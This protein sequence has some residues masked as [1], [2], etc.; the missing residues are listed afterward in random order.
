MCLSFACSFICFLVEWWTWRG[1][2]SGKPPSL[3]EVTE[4]S[5]APQNAM[6]AVGSREPIF[7]ATVNGRRWIFLGRQAGRLVRRPGKCAEYSTASKAAR[8]TKFIRHNWHQKQT[9]PPASKSKTTAAACLMP[10]ARDSPPP[11]HLCK[12]AGI[13]S[14][15]FAG[16]T[17]HQKR[18]P[19][20]D[21]RFLNLD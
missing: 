4:K 12:I 5:E 20:R 3:G 18:E 14:V 2:A 21:C 7:A 10:C 11:Q 17:A 1:G 13:Q 19:K 15:S 16:E 9:L 6:R 8:M